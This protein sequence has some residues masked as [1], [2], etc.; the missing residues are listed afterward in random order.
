MSKRLIRINP[1]D[2]FLKLT[3]MAGT[4][5]NVIL[6]DDRTY[7]GKLVSIEPRFLVLSDTRS[8]IHQLELSDL[9]EIVYDMFSVVKAN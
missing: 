6:N 5:L 7:F 3:G 2:A 1:N 4:E 8:H 9:Y